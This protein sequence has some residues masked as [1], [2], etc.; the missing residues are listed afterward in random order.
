MAQKFNIV[1]QLNLQGPTNVRSVVNDIKRQLS[2]VKVDVNLNVDRKASQTVNE[3]NKNLGN[4]GK[5]AKQAQNALNNLGKASASSSKATASTASNLNAA[6]TAAENFGKQSALAVKR[7]AAFSIGAGIMAGFVTALRSGT[8]AAIEFERQMVKIAQVTGRSLDGLGGLGREISGLAKGLGVASDELV[9]V[10]R[11]LAQTGLSARDTTK[12]LK[13]LA[14]SSLAPTFKDMANTAEGAIAIMRQFGVTADNLGKKLGSINALAGQ[15]AVESQDLIFAIRRAGG[16][17]QAAGGQLEE[18]LALFTSVRATTRESAETIATG[19]RTIF[20]RIQ[21]PKTIEFLKQ[22]GINLQNLQGQFV[23]PFEAINRLNKALS[24]LQTT[25]PRFSQIIE[26]L[27]GFRQVSKVIPLIQ[28]FGTAQKALQVALLGQGSLAKDAATAQQ[29]LATQIVKVREQFLALFRDIAGGDTFQGFAKG[30]LSL[31]SSLIKVGESIKPILPLIAALGALQGARFGFQF[32]RGFG[33][34]LRGGGGAEGLGQRIGGGPGGGAGGGAAAASKQIQAISQNTQAL[35]KL[36]GSINKLNTDVAK[37][38]TAVIKMSNRFGTGGLGGRRGRRGFATGGIVP[39]VGNT[40]SVPAMLTPG[41]FVIRKSSVK[42]YG[43]DNLQKL[44]TGGK[45]TANK[46]RKRAYAFDFDDTLAVSDAVVREGAE[47]PFVDFRGAR[48]ESFVQGAKATK[49]ASMA[50]RRASRGHDIF[51]VTARPGDA[52][53]RRGIGGF[54][55]RAG[56]PTKDIIGVGGSPG[57]GDTAQKKSTVLS[58]LVSQYGNI[59]FL[60]D[61]KENILAAKKLKGVR[62]ITARY[63]LGG[64]VDSGRGLA[65]GH[66]LLYGATRTSRPLT[67]AERRANDRAAQSRRGRA[68]GLNIRGFGQGTLGKKPIVFEPKQGDM[69]GFYLNP[70]NEPPKAVNTNTAAFTI[71]N[72]IFRRDYV[73]RLKQERILSQSDARTRVPDTLKGE[74]RGGSYASFGPQESSLRKGSTEKAISQGAISGM[75]AGIQKSMNSIIKSKAFNIKGLQ[76]LR[77]NIS[78]AKTAVATDENVIKTVSGFL[79]ESVI[80]SLT[81]AAPGG[82]KVPMDLPNITGPQRTK[83][84]EIFGEGSELLKIAEVKRSQS[85]LTGKDGLQKKIYGE[86]NIRKG[87]YKQVAEMKPSQKLGDPIQLASGGGI[88]GSDTVPALLTPGEFVVNRKSA[89]RIGYGALEKINRG[90]AQGFN[91]G[92][93]VGAQRMANGG[94]AGGGRADRFTAFADKASGALIGLSFAADALMST[95]GEVDPATRKTIQSIQRMGTTFLALSMT[96]ASINLGAKFTSIGVAIVSFSRQLQA[97]A[98]AQAAAGSNLAGLTKGFAG[99]TR[100]LGKMAM[101][102]GKIAGPAVLVASI[103]TTIMLEGKA[104]ADAKRQEALQSIEMAT[105]MREVQ[106]GLRESVQ[107]GTQSKAFS[108]ALEDGFADG[109][110]M[111]GAVL[112]TTFNPIAAG[113][114]AIGVGGASAVGSYRGTMAAPPDPAEFPQELASIARA[115][116]R[117]EQ[118]DI[119]RAGRRME[120]AG[121]VDTGGLREIISS[122]QAQQGAARAAPS[123]TVASEINESL[124]RQVPA[125][126]DYLNKIADGSTNLTDFNSR[127]GGAG[128]A[129]AQLISDITGAPV[130]DILDSVE[131]RIKIAEKAKAAEEKRLEAAEK[132]ARISAQLDT[133]S[134]ALSQASQSVSMLDSAMQANLAAA[135]GGRVQ[136]QFSG[137]AVQSGVLGM[138]AEGR[139][140][141]ANVYRQA[142]EATAPTAEIA[143][144]AIKTQ[145]VMQSLPDIL[146]NAAS[147][148]SLSGA[149]LQTTVEN[150]LR[151]RF[152]DIPIVKTIASELANQIKSRQGGSEAEFG[153]ELLADATT[154]AG[155]LGAEAASNLN[156]KLQEIADMR[157]AMEEK[158]NSAVQVRIQLEEDLIKRLETLRKSQNRL[159]DFR[160]TTL[161]PAMSGGSARQLTIAQIQARDIERQQV[162]MGGDRSAS[163]NLAGDVGAMAERM[164]L[165]DQER[166]AIRKRL[167]NEKLTL[168]QQD[169]LQQ[170]LRDLNDESQSLQRGL[171]A[172]ADTAEAFGELQ[173]VLESI[174]A[175]REVRAGA[176]T[177]IAF[178]GQEEMRNAQFGIL[179]ARGLAAGMNPQELLE[180]M[181]GPTRQFLEAIGDNESAILGGQTGTEVLRDATSRQIREMLR[182]TN[183]TTPDGRRLGEDEVEKL[184]DQTMNASRSEK[185]IMIEQENLLKR[186]AKA[187]EL[188]A[189][190]LEDG[191]ETQDKFVGNLVKI[192]TLSIIKALL[193]RDNEVAQRAAQDA[194]AEKTRAQT[195][196]QAADD[197]QNFTFTGTGTT[198]SFTQQQVDALRSDDTQQIFKDLAKANEK[199]AAGAR[200]NVGF[201]K[202]GAQ[203]GVTLAE[204]TRISRL[205]GDPRRLGAGGGATAAEQEA[206]EKAFSDEAENLLVKYTGV[207]RAEMGNAAFDRLLGDF[208]EAIDNNQ[209][210]DFLTTASQE[211]ARAGI[212]AATDRTR[213]RGEAGALGF[214]PDQIEGLQNTSDLNAV[215][216]SISDLGTAGTTLANAGTKLNEAADKLIEANKAAYKSS[217]VLDEAQADIDAVESRRGGIRLAGGGPVSHGTGSPAGSLTQ[218]T[219]TRLTVLTPGEFV[220]NKSATQRH[221]GT[222]EAINSGQ[223]ARTGGQIEYLRNGSNRSIAGTRRRAP[224]S[225]SGPNRGAADTQANFERLAEDD[226]AILMGNFQGFMRDPRYKSIKLK[227]QALVNGQLNQ[228]KIISRFVTRPIK[229]TSRGTRPVLLNS[230]QM[231]EWSQIPWEQRLELAIGDKAAQAHIESI[232]KR[233]ESVEQL[234][235]QLRALEEE[236]IEKFTKQGF[237]NIE[238]GTLRSGALSAELFAVEKD[239]ER[240]AEYLRRQIAL[241][242]GGMT[243]GLGIFADAVGFFDALS[244]GELADAGMAAFAGLPVLG[245]PGGLGKAA[246]LAKKIKDITKRIADTKAAKALFGAGDA[247]R[248][249]RRTPPRQLTNTS[250]PGVSGFDAPPPAIRQQKSQDLMVYDADTGKLIENPRGGQLEE[251][252]FSKQRVPNQGKV[253]STIFAK[254]K[255]GYK[256]LSKKQKW[257]IIGAITGAVMTAKYFSSQSERAS[258]QPMDELSGGGKDRINKYQEAGE[259]EALQ[260]LYENIGT[261][262]TG[263]IIQRLASGG[264]VGGHGNGDKVPALLTPGEFV[265]NKSSA[266]R[267][268]HASLQR[269]NKGGAVGRGIVQGAGAFG[270]E[271]LAADIQRIRKKREAELES[272]EMASPPL[273]VPKKDTRS[274]LQRLLDYRPSAGSYPVSKKSDLQKLRKGGLVQRLSNGGAVGYPPVGLPPLDSLDELLDELDEILDIKIRPPKSS[275]PKGKGGRPK[276]PPPGAPPSMVLPEVDLG[277]PVTPPTYTTTDDTTADDMAFLGIE[278][279]GRGPGG[280]LPG[281]PGMS[282]GAAANAQNAICTCIGASLT[283]LG[284][285]LGEG[286]EETNSS[287]S[288]IGGTVGSVIGNLFGGPV[289]G[290]LGQL[291]GLNAGSLMDAI[292]NLFGAGEGSLNDGINSL[293][294]FTNGLPELVARSFTNLGITGQ[295]IFGFMF[296]GA[297]TAFQ[298]L[299]TDAGLL[300]GNVMDSVM[301]GGTLGP[302]LLTMFSQFFGSPGSL[303]SGANSAALA[304]MAAGSSVLGPNA[305]MT[306]LEGLGAANDFVNN[307]L[308]IVQSGFLNVNQ[309]GQP[310]SVGGSAGVDA[311]QQGQ[312]VENAIRDGFAGVSLAGLDT[313]AGILTEIR[314]CICAGGGGL[315]ISEGAMT[316]FSGSSSALATSLDKF[317]S[318][319]GG[320]PIQ[321]QLTLTSGVNVNINGLD[322]LAPIIRA[323]VL[324]IVG[325]RIQALEG[326]LGMGGSAGSPGPGA[327]GGGTD[328]GMVML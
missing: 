87:R 111:F 92:G 57:P 291:L 288:T 101:G 205:S 326:K 112:I 323:E 235:A 245:T 178:G 3:L 270:F 257:A 200:A 295:D 248:T 302:D 188:M 154:I 115:R 211:R 157:I 73:K 137:G 140:V 202:L 49:I 231:R 298:N 279:T 17:F 21:R 15:F 19:F 210:N 7:F 72:P 249:T 185:Q 212:D 110:K 163:V 307:N 313:V 147:Q 18:L 280:I 66:A 46:N 194:Q 10:A 89:Q 42:K 48:G 149:P 294:G 62:A 175:E 271:K 118:A 180:P 50:K 23:G 260:N 14:Q 76:P 16:A 259:F 230:E 218:S 56:I 287:I 38:S 106:E 237:G 173:T 6:A 328:P 58:K 314:D 34:G 30:A 85:A 1:A 253:P 316:S 54:M 161:N 284:R 132:Q 266:K 278:P 83:M 160:R 13:A 36:T 12:A 275:P 109:A 233:F 196:K 171:E 252:D 241:S 146:R 322:S 116:A 96:M 239:L 300:G 327:A 75:K 232:T 265:I 228:E 125:L 238:G 8:K 107:A 215:L 281:T 150:E 29:S 138:A 102:I 64:R 269:L 153:K 37:L 289:G 67:V 94:A 124:A 254:V 264:T 26:E 204:D 167:E 11:I 193:A 148:Q 292:T 80:Q 317:T 170:S 35:S 9:D 301:S 91:R 78:A 176:L 127:L 95:F 55:N 166:E 120:L 219:D 217:T 122:I 126:Q 60:D 236:Y 184:I 90:E 198:T 227:A 191:L 311:Q 172:A 113:L 169:N 79:F 39:G 242:A 247:A 274:F 268:G 216:E 5:N 297:G 183:F 220:V 225:M 136:A 155:E 221:R 177:D 261:K 164:R 143:D 258:R 182:Q 45:K 51:V 303:I 98:A 226:P 250:G 123:A 68:R 131:A 203:G 306:G 315:G 119:A 186:S 272:A 20:T 234:L 65:A 128:P 283:D 114:A 179:G 224:G 325:E 99:A 93:V 312:N 129:I 162:A 263:G 28:Q 213:L 100:G 82:D 22:L 243:P 296:G 63:A 190:R 189:E 277:T 88:S 208:K 44:N 40:D 159:E 223:F 187:N 139:A 31:A 77:P 174:R 282:G 156:N 151:A 69:G 285:N 74:M 318:A 319:F 141:D 199:V 320:A 207:S 105:T 70:A 305:G 299:L 134:D 309:A 117:F 214:T 165:I 276:G 24:Q 321:H 240:Q 222:L 86:F 293:F 158:V 181:R 310:V 145:E 201:Q 267:I 244:N 33:G 103:F 32:L 52:S 2:G 246:G 262:R 135:R 273:P 43:S 59:T 251:Y 192:N 61:D 286:L 130:K 324:N 71:K 47:D 168:E 84:A 197:L 142:V 255:S 27:G 144:Q 121:G 41:E 229:K 209:M 133:F 4:L 206:A 81:G 25:D 308:P 108:N 256:G 104:L 290:I 152:G 195:A 304:N 53:T 97:A